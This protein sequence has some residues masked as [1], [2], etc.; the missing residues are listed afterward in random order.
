MQGG[1]NSRNGNLRTLAAFE[2]SEGTLQLFEYQL[3]AYSA[4]R[5]ALNFQRYPVPAPRKLHASL[6]S[7]MLFIY[8]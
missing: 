5:E 4:D 7:L 1:E 3:F 6:D 2:R 8:C